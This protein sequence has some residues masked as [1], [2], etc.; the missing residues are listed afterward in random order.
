MC[1]LTRY[2]VYA[3]VIGFKL[4][5]SFLTMLGERVGTFGEI[6]TTVDVLLE[7][8]EVAER[9]AKTDNKKGEM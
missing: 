6:T 9:L 7:R 3:A 5:F 2:V 1:D 4:G 8:K